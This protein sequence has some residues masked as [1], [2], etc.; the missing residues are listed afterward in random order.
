MIW[1][2]QWGM[3]EGTSD[4]DQET[5]LTLTMGNFAAMPVKVEK[6]VKLFKTHRCVLDFNHGFCKASFQE[7]PQ[8]KKEGA[9]VE[10]EVH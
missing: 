9:E 2:E 8:V 5:N 6:M 4:T 1:Q 10:V 7:I 3:I